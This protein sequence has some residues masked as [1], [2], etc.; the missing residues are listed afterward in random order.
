MQKD[1]ILQSIGKYEVL[2][3]LGR[4]SMGVVYKARDPEIGRLVAIKT[5]RKI[6]A[7]QFQSWDHA[8]ARFKIEA[9]SAGNLR[10]PNL[11]TI[12]EVNRDRD[13]PYIVMDYVEGEGLD[14]LISRQSKLDPQTT[15]NYLAQ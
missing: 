11:I 9:R 8:L 1:E 14:G 3:S 10:H 2:G 4:G 13:T 12:F 7:S 6:G 5:L 15:I